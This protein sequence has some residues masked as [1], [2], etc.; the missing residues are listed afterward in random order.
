MLNKAAAKNKRIL[1]LN[2]W[3]ADR[4]L[5]DIQKSITFATTAVLPMAEELLVSQ[6]ESKFL[7]LGRVMGYTVD[8]ITLLNRAHEHERKERF[9]PVLNEDIEGMCDK[10]IDTSSRDYFRH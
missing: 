9:K 8:S 4:Q 10:Y 1:P 6:N 7:D 3:G 5:P 2:K